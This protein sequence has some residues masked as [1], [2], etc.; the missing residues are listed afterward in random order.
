[1]TWGGKPAQQVYSHTKWS[2]NPMATDGDARFNQGRFMTRAQTGTKVQI[3]YRKYNSPDNSTLQEATLT[4]YDDD[5]ETLKKTRIKLKRTDAPVE[6]RILENG[7]G[8]I[9]IRYFLASDAIDNPASVMQ[10]LLKEFKN[11][12][13]KGLIVDVRDNPGGEDDL[14]ATMAGLLMNEKRHYEDIG[15]YSRMTGKFEIN[16][17]E[18][19]MSKPAQSGYKGNTAILINHNT[20]SSGEGLP[21]RLRGLPH[22]RIVGFTSTNGSFGVVSS[23]IQAEMPEGYLL[24]FPDGRS[25]D[26]NHMIQGDSN[27]DGQGGAAPDNQVPLNELTFAEKYIQGEDVELKAAVEALEGMN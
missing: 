11:K 12:A 20:G 2:E 16:A 9:K 22:I 15:Y 26:E 19:L 21:L 27:H 1:V 10:E 4:A 14:A 7:Y 5:Y 18:S 17:A 6:G 23:P 24:Q 8:Y 3:Q 25:L 13:V